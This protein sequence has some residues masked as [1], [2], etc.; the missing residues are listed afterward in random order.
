MKTKAHEAL[1]ASILNVMFIG[2]ATVGAMDVAFAQGSGAQDAGASRDST[3]TQTTTL[4]TVEVTGSHIRRVGL[5]GSNPVITIGSQ[6]ILNSGEMT[7]GDVLAQLPVV[8]GGV[9]R[10]TVNNGGGDGTTQVGVRGLGAARTLVL[11]DGHRV[12]FNDLNKVP[13]D[14]VQRIEVLTDGASAIYGSDAIAGVINIILKDRYSGARVRFNYGISDRNDGG[15]RGVA[16]TIGQATQRGSIYAGIDYNKFDSIL[17]N[18]RAFSKTSLRFTTAPDGTVTTTPLGSV[19]QYGMLDLPAK[20]AS[21]TGCTTARRV[22]LNASALTPSNS[23]TNLSDYHCYDAD[24]D[25][26]NNNRGNYLVT[27]RERVD[28]YFHGLYHATESI[29]LYATWLHTKTNASRG[30]EPAALLSQN[31]AGLTVSKDSYYNP[32]GVDFQTPGGSAYRMRLYPLGQQT[33]RNTNTMNQLM[34]GARGDVDVLGKEWSWDVGFNYGHVSTV[35][36]R[37]GYPIAANLVKGLATPSMLDAAS[38]QVVCVGTPNDIGT[39][40]PG[41]TPWDPFNLESPSAQAALRAAGNNSGEMINAWNIE[42]IWHAGASGEILDLPAGPVSLAVGVDYREEYENNAVGALLAIDPETNTC[43]LGAACSQHV[44][45]GFNVKEGYA[46]LYVPVLKDVPFVHELSATLGDRYSRYSTYGSSNNWKLGVEYRPVQ[47]LLLRGTVSTVFRAPQIDDIYR[48]PQAAA[49]L[50]TGDPCDHITVANAA[51]SG[52]PLDGSFVD[53]IVNQNG[54][55]GLWSGSKAANFALGP[56]HGSSFDFGAV[57]S[58]DFA[59]GLSL[60]VD[61]WRIYLN[62]AIGRA[63]AQ[64]VIDLCFNGVTKFCPLVSREP[65]GPNAGQITRVI[66]PIANLGRVDTKGVDFTVSYRFP[67]SPIGQFNATLYT[68]YMDQFKVQ[69]SPGTPGGQVLSGAGTMGTKGTSFQAACLYS[70]SSVCLYPRFRAVGNLRWQWHDWSAGWRVRYLSPFKIAGSTL[71]RKGLDRYGAWTYHD[72]NMNYSIKPINTTLSVGVRNV[73]DK[74]PPML[75]ADRTTNANTDPADF[76]VI[77]R[78]YWARVTVD[79]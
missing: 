31:V 68:T 79:F 76:D 29:D 41:C 63:N 19:G 48:A 28:G 10:P 51:C 26:W 43:A 12:I 7:L 52:V 17:Q 6:E 27:P 44:S 11:V 25:S 66:Q 55:N 15:Q 59:P 24:T 34:L 18:D 13:V 38:G 39:V 50:L 70:P 40:I 20:V 69:T 71:N 2:T 5:E 45:G 61:L 42:R 64:T 67:Q 73:F 16:F 74:Q 53:A 49:T 62:D 30:L 21:G 1:V 75:Y 9:M 22:A 47:S 56:E 72:L 77:G 58:P 3:S 57:Y 36:T 65:S 33:L 37:I 4:E 8:T 23:P 54:I 46:E 14:A 60:N 35:N 78:Y 32:F